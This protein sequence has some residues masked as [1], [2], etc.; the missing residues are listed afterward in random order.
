MNAADAST[1]E[2]RGRVVIERVS[3]EIDCGQFAIKRAAGDSVIVAADIFADGHD[4]I[5]AVLQY[6]QHS[7]AGRPEDRREVPMRELGNDRWMAQF[8]VSQAG[9][10]DYTLQAW[11]DRFGSWRRDVLKKAGAGEAAPIDLL[12]GAELIDEASRKAPKSDAARL[13]KSAKT[14]REVSLD[15]DEGSVVERL[16]GLLNEDLTGL[17]WKYSE[18]RFATAY[19]KELAVSVDREKAR[20]SAWYEMFP[21]SASAEPGRHGTF[22]DCEA[23]LPYIAEMGFDVLYLPPIHPIGETH[24]KGPNN[25]PVAGPGD[26]G[27]PWAIGSKQGGHKSIHP[28][29]GTI[30]DF[31]R[32]VARSRESGI[33]IAL[34][35]AFQ[36]SP[37]HPYISEHREWFRRLPDGSIQYAENPPKKYEDIYPFD[38][39][40]DAWRELWQ[41]L[42]SVVRYW[43]DQGVRIFRVD[44]PHTKAFGFWQWL[45]SG[46]KSEYPEVLFLA[47]AF[48]RPKVMYRL[49]KLGFTHSYTYFAW[50]N[51]KWELTQYFTELSQTEVSEYLRP[52]LWPNTPDILTENLQFGGRPVFASR[53]ILAATLGANYGIY[54]PA[55]ELGES[56]PLAPGREEYLDAEKYEIRHWDIERLDSLQGLIGRVNR[57]RRE[58][59]ALQSDRNLRFHA[60]DNEALIAYSKSTDDLLNVVLVVVNLD[61]H[62]TRSGWVVLPL[63]ELGL[64]PDQPYQVHDLLTD[65]RYL[66]HGPRNYVELNPHQIPAHIF[67][68]RHRV[69]TERDF[70]Y[71][72]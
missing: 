27:S 52:H 9:R 43:I 8:P 60:V 39:E 41:E 45:I 30:E 28:E 1:A 44:N 59:A 70:D 5:S 3:P 26:P 42:E 40:C 71:F 33:E 58:N 10:Y 56:R 24:R 68:L 23:R 67:R 25:N 57:A 18:R 72:M 69:R 47:E 34:D 37:D 54:G 61:P 15:G 49:A 6:W 22:K 51:T 32:L 50:R 7:T 2:S 48:T 38:F 20:C 36:C 12:V 4:A 46:I 21:R 19:E 64:D 11:I 35:L 66:W 53:L 16:S 65:L 31:R 13:L 14:L 17:I 62:Y 55:Y 29:L 63:E